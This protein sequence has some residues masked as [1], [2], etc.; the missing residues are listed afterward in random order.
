M[1][2]GN[3]GTLS[4]LP[5]QKIGVIYPQQAERGHSHSGSCFGRRLGNRFDGCH[6]LRREPCIPL[7]G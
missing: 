4:N 3:N 1:I 2:F 5:A 7:G 6:H